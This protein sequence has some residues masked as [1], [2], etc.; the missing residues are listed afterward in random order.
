MQR[1]K[2]LSIINCLATAMLAYFLTVPVHELFHMLTHYVYGGKVLIYSASAVRQAEGFDYMNLSAFNRIMIAGGS[3]SILNAIIGIILIIIVLKATMGPTVRLF[4]IQLMGAHLSVGVGYFMIGGLFGAG[5]WGDV[6][7]A[8]ADQPGLVSVLRIVLSIVG[9]LG[10]VGVF[11]LLNYTSYYFIE[12]TGNRKERLSVAFRL[13][14]LMLIVGFPI[15]MIVTILSPERITGELSIGLGALYNFMWIPFLWGFL[16]T[17]VMVRPPKKS[18][19]L[20]RL[21][22]KPNWILFAVAVMLILVDIFVFG[23]GIKLN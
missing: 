4:L 5:D 23:P 9:C 11:F 2:D 12:D 16:F 20:Y 1:K 10:I 21:P 14:L 13:H 18:R 7:R 15:G 8:L 6:F 22:S 17:G 3:A 19:F